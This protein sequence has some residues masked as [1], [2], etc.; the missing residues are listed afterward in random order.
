MADKATVTTGSLVWVPAPPG[1]AGDR[2]WLKAEVLKVAPGSSTAAVRDEDGRELEVDA[3]GCPLQNPAAR[4]GVEVRS[5]F[6][7]RTGAVSPLFLKGAPRAGPA[8]PHSGLVAPSHAPRHAAC[9]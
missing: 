6:F 7:F 4:M 5:F 2:A 8:W 9:T 1:D 3:A